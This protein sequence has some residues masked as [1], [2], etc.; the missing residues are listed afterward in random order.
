MPT[1]HGRK[2]T[3]QLSVAELGN[4]ITQN[5]QN[6]QCAQTTSSITKTDLEFIE[7]SKDG[8]LAEQPLNGKDDSH[9][10]FLG[11]HEDMPF[12]MVRAGKELF[13]PNAPGRRNRRPAKTVKQQ[14]TDRPAVYDEDDDG[15]AQGEQMPRL[16]SDNELSP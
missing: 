4:V 3:I 15:A 1:N 7:T 8:T 5:P 14:K 13:N 9:V 16:H 10:Q 12:F 11:K 6:R 2:T